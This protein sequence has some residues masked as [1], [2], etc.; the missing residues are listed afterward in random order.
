MIHLHA[1]L[2]CVITTS[3]HV[4]PPAVLVYYESFNKNQHLLT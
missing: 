2:L 1:L 3:K 4:T